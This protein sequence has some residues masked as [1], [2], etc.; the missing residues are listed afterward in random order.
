M[1]IPFPNILD[2]KK[3][4]AVLGFYN[5]PSL[6]Y[7]QFWASKNV[8]NAYGPFNGV[9]GVLPLAPFVERVFRGETRMSRDIQLRHRNLGTYGSLNNQTRLLYN[10][11]EFAPGSH[12][13]DSQTAFLRIQTITSANPTFPARSPDTLSDIRVMVPSLF[14]SGGTPLLTI[15]GVAPDLASAVFGDTPPSQTMNIRLPA[16]AAGLNL[17]NHG[18]GNL[19]YSLDPGLPL[20][21]LED[22]ETL[23][24]TTGLKDVLIL[25]ANG[26]NPEF[27]ASMTSA[28]YATR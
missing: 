6:L 5:D 3:G 24:I 21:K 25:C 22:N 16:S 20:V 8:N 15:G 11:D 14:F 23:S 28:S 9:P 4:L 19:L 12:P 1:S 2:R 27:S 17:I 7:Y 18:P 26:S 10:P 13:P